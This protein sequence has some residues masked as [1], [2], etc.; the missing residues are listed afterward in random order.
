MTNFASNIRRCI[1]KDYS[2]E[3]LRLFNKASAHVDDLFLLVLTPSVSTT[4]TLPFA[5]SSICLWMLRIASKLRM[6]FSL[7]HNGSSNR[8]KSEKENKH[9]KTLLKKVKQQIK[10]TL[11]FQIYTTIS[12]TTS[13]S[14]PHSFAKQL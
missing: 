4:S 13:T 2:N 9:I 7:L 8:Q 6:T 14:V 1:T 3:I 10:I 12:G 11:T 5:S